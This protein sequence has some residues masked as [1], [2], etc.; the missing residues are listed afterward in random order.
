MIMP[1][2]ACRPNTTER[3]LTYTRETTAASGA[4]GGKPPVLDYTIP[5][6]SR[7]I[8]RVFLWSVSASSRLFFVFFPPPRKLTQ[9]THKQAT[10]R[11]TAPAPHIVNRRQTARWQMNTVTQLN[12]YLHFY[13]SYVL[14]FCLFVFRVRVCACWK[15]Y[16][17]LVVIQP[18]SHLSVFFSLPR[19][20]YV[21]YR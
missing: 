6:C 10:H 17:T 20:G 18:N 9:S 3:V 12:T 4:G 7:R 21:G 16:H 15:Y 11:A 1:E 14:K 2:A 5:E 13:Y 19:S 8:Y